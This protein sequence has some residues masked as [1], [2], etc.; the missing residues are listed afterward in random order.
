MDYLCT[1]GD[2]N[3][4]KKKKTLMHLMQRAVPY[5]ISWTPSC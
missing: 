1:I 5:G 2:I 4:V 3:V